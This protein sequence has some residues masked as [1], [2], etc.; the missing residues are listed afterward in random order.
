MKVVA[1]CINKVVSNIND[2]ANQKKVREEILSLCKKH[3][4]YPDINL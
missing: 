1:D 4:L 3:P 2:E